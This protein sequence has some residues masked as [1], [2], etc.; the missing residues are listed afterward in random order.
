M[1]ALLERGDA[2][3]V[4]ICVVGY[5]VRRNLY[6]VGKLCRIVKRRRENAVKSRELVAARIE[7]YAALR[8]EPACKRLS[9]VESARARSYNDRTW[10]GRLSRPFFSASLRLC[11]KN[12]LPL[13]K[14]HSPYAKPVEEIAK[15][16][17]E[18]RLELH[19]HQLVV[20]TESSRER[21]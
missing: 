8:A 4:K 21:L 13:Q 18:R 17:V 7:D 10:L 1:I 12:F 2:L 20:E 9:R 15:H 11:V 19:R 16:L 5:E 6:D 14:P 3:L